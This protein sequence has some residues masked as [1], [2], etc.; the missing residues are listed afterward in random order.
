[1]SRQLDIALADLL[2]YDNYLRLK[3]RNAWLCHVPYYSKYGDDMLELDI[4]MRTRG[5]FVSIKQS[6][7]INHGY[8]YV[9]SY[10]LCDVDKTIESWGTRI[11]EASADTMPKAL[12][13]AAYTML[14][15]KEWTEG[16]IDN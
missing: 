7:S 15:G 6:W 10:A 14:A 5:Y 4:E 2:Q 8:K 3:N 11:A 1:M 9:V 12:A 13:L 16:G